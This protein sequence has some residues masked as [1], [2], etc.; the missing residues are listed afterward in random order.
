MD[1]GSIYNKLEDEIET[2]KLEIKTQKL[3][4]DFYKSIFKTHKNSVI[5]NLSIKKK[6]GKKVWIDHIR[7]NREKILELDIDDDV[8]EWLKPIKCSR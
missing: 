5:F 1:I 2:Q 3:E 7:E 6:K 4:I 8:K